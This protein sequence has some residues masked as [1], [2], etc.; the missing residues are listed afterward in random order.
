MREG[1]SRSHQSGSAANGRVFDRGVFVC[2]E[3]PSHRC[4]DGI[5]KQA[6]PDALI[7]VELPVDLAAVMCGLVGPCLVGQNVG[8]AR[9]RTSFL[10]GLFG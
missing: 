2:F 10:T 8:F 4:S 9:A 5:G 3:K 6:F 7:G 1:S